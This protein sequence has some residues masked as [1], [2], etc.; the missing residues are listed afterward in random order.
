MTEEI[1]FKDIPFF[2]GE[3]NTDNL[4][5]IAYNLLPPSSE[6]TLPKK[7]FWRNQVWFTKKYGHLGAIVWA[8]SHSSHM[9]LINGNPVLRIWTVN[10]DTSR[11]ELNQA[12][13]SSL[14]NKLGNPKVLQS[15]WHKTRMYYGSYSITT[16]EQVQV[17]MQEVGKIYGINIT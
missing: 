14:N 7:W 6:D 3:S 11:I 2:Y 17:I 8:R 4:A 16:K 5:K 1:S 9:L 15:K 10:P 12:V 13:F